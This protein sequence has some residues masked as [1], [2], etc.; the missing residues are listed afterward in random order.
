M[1]LAT[2]DISCPGRI[3]DCACDV[4]GDNDASLVERSW[5]AIPGLL[6][7]LLRDSG[8]G[9]PLAAFS[10]GG[11]DWSL[12]AIG[13]LFGK[14]KVGNGGCDLARDKA[15]LKESL[16]DGCSSNVPD[17]DF[18]NLATA[19]V[20]ESWR[21]SFTMPFVGG[22]VLPASRAEGPS[23]SFVDFSKATSLVSIFEDFS[24]SK[25]TLVRVSA[26]RARKAFMSMSPAATSDSP[27]N[28]ALEKLTS[29]GEV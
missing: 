23:D 10:P 7:S 20:A 2:P 25:K 29:P 12:H 27:D 8:N 5:E 14:E 1:S 16:E 6:I 26:K 4:N 17:K 22:I 19:F 15:E 21:G 13:G 9:Q 24:A 3:S 11:C 18:T 28:A